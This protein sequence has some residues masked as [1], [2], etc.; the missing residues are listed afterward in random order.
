[1]EEK[2]KIILA[3]PFTKPVKSSE[4]IVKQGDQTDAR[5][6]SEPEYDDNAKEQEIRDSG[7]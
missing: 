2:S 3:K 1:M 6:Y 5:A 7:S 4:Y